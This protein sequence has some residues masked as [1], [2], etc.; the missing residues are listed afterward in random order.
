MKRVIFEAHGAPAEM[1]KVIDET[2]PEP[3]P[4][5]VRLKLEVMPINPADLLRIEGRYGD[6]PETLP[7]TPGAEALGVVDKLGEGVEGLS[8]GQR[9]LP[10]GGPC[11]QEMLVTSAKGVIPVPEGADPEQAAMLKANPATAEIML[12]LAD[13]ARGDW[14][15][16]SA[17]N[18]AVG[19]LVIRF[20]KAKGLHTVNIVRRAELMPELRELGADAVV[21]DDRAGHLS[22]KIAQAAGAPPKLALDAVGGEMTGELASACGKGGVVAVYGLLSGQR[23]R[24]DVADLVFRDVH[25]R[26]FWLAD[27]FAQAGA[28]EIRRVY[29]SLLERLQAGEIATPVEARYPLSRVREAVA[30]AAREGRSGKVLLTAD[31]G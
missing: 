16:Q 17:A 18:S 21:V 1:V 27:W 25:L 14:V 5:Q 26:G 7:A 22:D 2:A 8:V 6:R 30:H 31:P 24:I 4:G 28:E 13:L 20:A 9:V 23:A 12:G 29:A 15:A 10:L 11:W 19:R 3:G